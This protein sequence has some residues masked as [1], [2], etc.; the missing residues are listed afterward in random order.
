MRR[1]DVLSIGVR[2]G[3]AGSRAVIVMIRDRSTTNPT[4][5]TLMNLRPLPPAT[6]LATTGCALY[7]LH[8]HV[9][10]RYLYDVCKIFVF[11]DPLPPVLIWVRYTV[12]NPRNL[13]YFVHM[14]T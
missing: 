12:L 13:P 4:D 6:G 11:L 10:G 14:A 8:G 7:D 1:V 5:T 3:R 9:F 2:L